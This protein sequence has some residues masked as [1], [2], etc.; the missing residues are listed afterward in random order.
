M[1]HMQ[2]LMRTSFVCIYL[3][4]LNVTEKYEDPGQTAQIVCDRHKKVV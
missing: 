3:E 1:R 2:S 4:F